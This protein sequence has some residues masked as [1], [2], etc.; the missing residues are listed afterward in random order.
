MN[1]AFIV[2]L[3]EE[4]KGLENLLGI[5]VFYCGVGK[6]NSSIKTVDLINDGFSEII[7]IG[8]CG[9][10]K[11]PIG[12]ILKIG[13]VFQDIDG[14]P[15]CDY[16]HTPFEINSESIQ[17]SPDSE[18]TCFTTDYFYDTN[19]KEKYSSNFLKK[20]D[21]TSVVDMECFSIAKVCKIKNIKFSSYKWVSDSGGFDE[22]ITNCEIGLKNFKSYFLNSV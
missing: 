13:K 22:W 1:K 2:A 14:S 21:E 20:I 17:L 18:I 12:T 9:S 6:I 4:T 5:P 7:N 10:T 19:Q 11:F 15:I 3:K 8:S 16:G